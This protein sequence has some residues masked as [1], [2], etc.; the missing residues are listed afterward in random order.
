MDYR[1]A[2]LE[3]IGLLAQ[4][5][6]D[7]IRDEGHCN[8]MTLAELEERMA[9]WLQGEYEAVLF[10][11]DGAPIGYALYRW[12]PEFVY[13]RHFFVRPEFRRR[14]VGRAALAWLCANVWRD[15]RRVRVDVLSHNAAGAVFWRATGFSDY[16][17]TMEMDL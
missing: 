15:A 6:H 4:M 14:G 9:G 10:E 13:L 7:L 2:G 11:E 1:V 8:P 16:A 12:M 5:N 17:V 3:N